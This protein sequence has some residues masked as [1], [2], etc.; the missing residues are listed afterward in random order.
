[1]VSSCLSTLLKNADIHR[2]EFAAVP[3]SD[4]ILS[5]ILACLLHTGCRVYKLWMIETSMAT[6]SS[7]ILL[8]FLREA[9][10]TGIWL[11]CIRDCTPHSFSPEVLQFIVTRQLLVVNRFH[12]SF[13][14]IYDDMLAKLTATHFLIGAPNMITMNGLKSFVERLVSGK[15]KVIRGKIFTNFLLKG[16]SFP[17]VSNSNLERLV[18]GKQKV[19]RGKIFTNFLLKGVSFPKVSNSNLEVMVE[20]NYIEF[21]NKEEAPDR[22]FQ[23]SPLDLSKRNPMVAEHLLFFVNDPMFPCGFR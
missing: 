3:L 23:L 9:A 2:L 21:L 12:D 16:V 8:R 17:K 15:Q 7:S 4:D 11:S 1:M 19:I 18:S 6:V 22:P 5:A 10:C 13:I 14:P 20:E